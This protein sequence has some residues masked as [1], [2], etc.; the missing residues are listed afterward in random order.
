MYQASSEADAKDNV[1]AAT[2]RLLQNY[3]QQVPFDT[4]LDFVFSK[5]PLTG[6]LNENETV[7]KFGFNMYQLCK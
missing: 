7:L 4:M 5:I 1:V 3:P 2:C 6:D